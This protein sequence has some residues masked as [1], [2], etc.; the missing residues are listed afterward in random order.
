[1]YISVDI[2]LNIFSLEGCGDELLKHLADVFIFRLFTLI[3]EAIH[4]SVINQ[5]LINPSRTVIG[6]F[7][8]K[9]SSRP[10]AYDFIRLITDGG[11]GMVCISLAIHAAMFGN[12]SDN[13]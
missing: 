9:K 8:G 12:H 3:G 13:T 7:E 1:M 11:T 5:T 4:L 6:N 2:A 10:I